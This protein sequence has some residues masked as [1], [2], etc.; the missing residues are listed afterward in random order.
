[1][2]PMEEEGFPVTYTC[3][4][5]RIV[6]VGGGELSNVRALGELLPSAA[7]KQ[8][9]CASSSKTVFMLVTLAFP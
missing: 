7:G 9:V 6:Y 5:L 8:Q 2:H 4:P 1:M 3:H